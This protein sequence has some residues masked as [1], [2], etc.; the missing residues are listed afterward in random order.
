MALGIAMAE[1]TIIISPAARADR[2]DARLAGSDQYLV[3]G[4]A[5]PLRD[6]ALTL[7]AGGLADESDVIVLRFAGSDRDILRCGLGYAV[8]LTTEDAA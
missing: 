7:L 6:C 2:H 1:H 4:T 8:E 3:E 5:T